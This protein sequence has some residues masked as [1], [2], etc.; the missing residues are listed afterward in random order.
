VIVYVESNFLLELA[1][2]QEQAA[3]AESIL[4]LAESGALTLIFPSFALSEPF[5]NLTRRSNERG[6]AYAVM[7]QQ[8]R[9]LARSGAHQQVAAQF[10]PVLGLLARVGTEQMN[11]LVATVDRLL[12]AGSPTSLDQATFRQA[13][14]YQNA[15]GLS[16]QDAIIYAIVIADLGRQDPVEAK[17]FIRRD[18]QGFADSRIKAELRQHNCRYIGNF[19]DGLSYIQSAL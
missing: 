6:Q 17:C 18:V 4:A 15:Y 12:G 11:T 14:L 10:L 13:Q 3:A 9:D 16:P 19:A 7:R 5:S 1:L 8:I 2:T